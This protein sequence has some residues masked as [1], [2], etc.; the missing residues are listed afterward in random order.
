[1]AA[2]YFL[3]RL[4]PDFDTGTPKLLIIQNHRFQ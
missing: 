1:M 3:Y 4:S 2:S